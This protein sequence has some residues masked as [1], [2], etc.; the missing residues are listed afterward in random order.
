MRL[1]Q[2]NEAV[3]ER[4]EDRAAESEPLRGEDHKGRDGG[5]KLSLSQ[6][7]LTDLTYF[8]LPIQKRPVV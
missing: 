5:G 1:T 3:L 8:W 7:A 6:T 4:E 2:N